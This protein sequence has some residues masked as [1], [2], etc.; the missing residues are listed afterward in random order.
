MNTLVLIPGSRELTYSFHNDHSCLF[1]G[2]EH[3]YGGHTAQDVA[4]AA[5]LIKVTLSGKL[6]TSTPQAIAVRMVHGG[7]SFAKPVQLDAQVRE[8]LERLIAFVPSRIPIE[9]QLLDSIANLYPGVPVVLF[10]ETSFFLGL[11]SSE[12]LYGIPAELS[13][14]PLLRR[15]GLHGLLHEHTTQAVAN[16]MARRGH[17]RKPRLISICLDPKPELV[18]VHGTRPLMST[19]GASPLE[20]L[21]G[22][23]ICGDLDPGVVLHLARHL[24]WAPEKIA[25]VLTNSSGLS[26]LAD[27]EVTISEVLTATEPGLLLARDL[28]RYRLLQACGAGVAGLRGIDAIGYS[29]RFAASGPALHAWLLDHLPAGVRRSLTISEPLVIEQDLPTILVESV[30]NFM[31]FH[32]TPGNASHRALASRGPASRASNGGT[33]VHD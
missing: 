30:R 14:E 5:R 8:Q 29:G 20:G 3:S 33:H 22:Q 27:R 10:F 32:E 4:F 12:F 15:Y 13:N 31:N 28:L 23:H 11:R 25:D 21:P 6:H 1:S 18:A 19:G 9:L 16:E 7:D 2:V 24:D 26:A 17:R